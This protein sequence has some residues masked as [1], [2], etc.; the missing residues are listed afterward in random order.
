M[1]RRLR[2]SEPHESHDSRGAAVL[3]A[4]AHGAYLD[5]AAEYAGIGARTLDRYIAEGKAAAAKADAGAR[6]NDTQ[7]AR[8]AGAPIKERELPQ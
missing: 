1:P 7:S 3:H 8:D 6:V 2:L 5:T 4:L